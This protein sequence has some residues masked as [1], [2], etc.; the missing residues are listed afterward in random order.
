MMQTHCPACAAVFRVTPEQLKARH[1]K[2]RCGECQQVFN[3]LDTLLDAT[4]ESA[5]VVSAPVV[6]TQAEIAGELAAPDAA[7][8]ASEPETSEET[9]PA[10]AKDTVAVLPTEPVVLPQADA[11][12]SGGEML[13]DLQGDAEMVSQAET[14]EP[15]DALPGSAAVAAEPDDDT[16]RAVTVDEEPE[17]TVG[18]GEPAAVAADDAPYRIEPELHETPAARHPWWWSLASL[19]LLLPLLAQMALHYR[20]ELATLLPES[21]PL[22][23]AVCAQFECEIAL[24]RKVDLLSIEASD[25]HPDPQ[26][27]GQLLLTA[28][29]KNRAPF[30]QTYPHLELTL[31]DTIDQAVLRKVLAPGEYLAKASN[32]AAGFAANGDVSVTLSLEADSAT[33]V[34][35][36]GYRLYLFY[37]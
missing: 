32:P 36:A 10:A 7:P 5:P 6:Q 28:T 37:P 2:V 26:Y 9:A 3:A 19:L 12:G 16:A 15:L 1:G 31:T 21:K 22:L 24:P 35:A 17:S 27:K 29:L 25:L 34:S 13:A 33:N 4:P 30:V 14:E 11:A 8:P 20:V 18:D 23:A